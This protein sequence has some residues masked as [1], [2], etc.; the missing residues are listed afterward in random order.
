MMQIITSQIKNSELKNLLISFVNT[1]Q[2]MNFGQ[3]AIVHHKAFGGKDPEILQLAA[4]I[5]LLILS[6]DIFDDLEDLDN[7]QEPWMQIDHSIALNAAT[8]LYTLSQ[9][10]I[11]TLS[12]PYK[13]Q[14]LTALL[15]FSVQAMEGQHDDLENTISNEEE[16]LNVMKRKSGSLTALASVCG[17]LL[18]NANYPEVE[19][20]SYQIGI[21]AQTDND[22]RDLFNPQKNDVSVHKKSLALLYLQKGY[23]EHARE[24]LAFFESNRDIKN[25]FGSFENY[26]QKLV[27]AGVAQ[28]LN[29]I[30][31][32]SIN[33]ATRIIEGLNI[34]LDHIEYLKSHLI[35]NLKPTNKES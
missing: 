3:L 12:S 34:D 16:C 32:I 8:T 25:E 10:T 14:I 4:S 20:Y 9:Q 19:E 27:D 35:I 22:F 17:M 13:H 30:K 11:L 24:V 6:F 33:R 29:V 26:K 23:N 21:A 5:E 31:Q 18:A 2:M 28:Y 7:M 1:K 15:Q